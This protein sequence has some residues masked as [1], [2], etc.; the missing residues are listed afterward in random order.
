M[1]SEW[2]NLEEQHHQ[3]L[4]PLISDFQQR[5]QERIRQPV[6]DF[7][8]EYYQSN[9]KWLAQWR[10]G[11]GT[12]LKGKAASKFLE[13]PRY[14][15]LA[16][17]VSLDPS[18]IESKLKDRVKWIVT[19]LETARLR[20]PRLNCYGLHEW[21]MV[22]KCSNIR[23][24]STPLRLSP[25]EIESVV[26]SHPIRCGHYDAFRF[27]TPE[28]KPLNQLSPEL[29]D[30][31]EHEQ[32]GCVHFNM[33]LYKWCYKCAPWTSAEL[34]RKCFFHAIRAREIDMRASPY[35]VKNLG[36]SPILIETAVGKKEY[37]D[38]QEQLMADGKP[39]LDQLLKELR[40]I[41]Q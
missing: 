2:R 37:Q 19:L 3:L 20:T 27:F 12:A 1:N 38:C 21:A 7:L 6:I 16:G 35:D 26:E 25:E 33:D 29:E 8:F 39:L 30:R 36:L 11:L 28:A 22:Y 13:D 15:E 17:V 40:A 23:H 14:Q 9:R 4:D 31:E 5:R 32:F 10:P 41:L 34:T 18:K 24:E